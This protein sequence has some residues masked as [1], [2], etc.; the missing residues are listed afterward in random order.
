MSLTYLGHIPAEVVCDGERY[1]CGGQY[2]RRFIN[3]WREAPRQWCAQSGLYALLKIS[4]YSGTYQNFSIDCP[5]FAYSFV[6]D[7]LPPP[8]PRGPPS[9]APKIYIRYEYPISLGCD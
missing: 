7:Q 5:T 2:I 1:P 9:G 8:P 3:S 6:Y 4:E